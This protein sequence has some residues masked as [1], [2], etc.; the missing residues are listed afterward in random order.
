MIAASRPVQRPSDAKLMVIDAHGAIAH[1]ARASLAELLGPGDVVV[2]NDAATLP[3]SLAGVHAPTGAPI[4]IR[5]AQRASLDPRDA[6]EFVAVVF[7]AGDRRMRTEDRPP[8]PALH[9]ADVLVLGPLRAT[10]RRILAHPRLVALAFDGTPARIWSGLAAHGQPIQYAYMEPSLAM[11]DVWTPVAGA[12]VAFEAPS[13]GFALDWRTLRALRQRG[14]AFATL[15]HAAGISSTGDAEL[16]RRLP[17]DEPYG[18]APST[19]AAIVRARARG[20]RVVAVG[21]SVVRALESSFAEHGRVR[22]G[23]G[24]AR[25]RIGP[26]TPLNVVDA[27]LSGTH[28]PGSSH[29]ELLRGFTGDTTLRR[30]DRELEAHGYRTHEFGDSVFVERALHSRFGAFRRTAL[31]AAGAVR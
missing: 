7:G 16:D 5:L 31:A 26:E 22:P 30:A 25:L 27:M 4:E 23:E 20:K 9:E 6:R 18:V 8:P 17:L 24:I 10:V 15:T 14:A 28:E 1:R 19:A 3:A 21:T 11:W 2:A 12:P 29:Y 13:A